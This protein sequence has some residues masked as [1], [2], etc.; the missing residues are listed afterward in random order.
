MKKLVYCIVLLILA[1]SCKELYTPPVSSPGAGYLVVEGFINNGPEPTTIKLTR[2]TR[3]V[4]TANIIYERNAR[5]NIEGDNGESYPLFESGEGVYTTPGEVLNNAAEYRLHIFTAEGKE[6]VSAYSAVKA[7][8]PVDSISWK[9]D[10]N[11]VHLFINTH[12]PL[13]NTKY[14]QWEY[15][16]TWEFHSAFQSSLIYV[17]TPQPDAGSV[18]SVGNRLPNGTVDTTIYKCWH[19]PHST[20]IILGSSEKLTTDKILYPLLN[21][22]PAAQQLSVLYSIIVKQHAVSKGNY[23]FLQKMKKN[24]EQLGTI[25]DAQPSDLNGNIHCVS[26]PAEQVVGYVEVSQLQAQR[27]Y[28]SNRDVPGWNYPQPCVEINLPLNSD[29]IKAY[30]LNLIPTSL[31]D[32]GKFNAA[33]PNCVDCTLTGSNIRPPFWP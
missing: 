26:N 32:I 12:D 2:T 30:G 1:V 3:L 23:D 29:S 28:I 14:Y 31:G 19:S 16:E 5:V 21:I 15:E 13:N 33:E 4:D 25:F 11:G 10:N 22:A 18:Y 27:I 6:Y 20:S 24:T 7:T 9:R 8:P 17:I